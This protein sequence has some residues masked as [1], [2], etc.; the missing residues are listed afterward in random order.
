VTTTVGPEVREAI[1]ERLAELEGQ[2]EAAK[3]HPG[4]WLRHT[5]AVDP[6]SGEEFFFRFEDGWEWQWD[7]LSAYTRQQLILR[8]KARQLG[9]SWLGIGYCAWKCITRPGMR[10]L[11]VSINET[12]AI[13]LVNRAWDLWENTP[14]HLRFD[15]KVIK[16]ERGRPSSRIEWEFPDGR[17]SSLLAMPSTPRAGHG[18]TAGVIFLD[19]FG[20]HQFAHETYKAFI[21]VMA[22]SPDTQL[23]IVST[24][25]GYGNLFYELWTEAA[26]RD[27]SAVFIGADAHP[28]RDE[29]WFKRMRR[30]L[31]RADMAEQYPL[32]AAEAFTGTAGCWFDTEALG[33]YAEKVRKPMRRGVFATADDG[34][35]ATFSDRPDG[36]LHI[37]DQPEKDR[38]YALYADVATGRGKDFTAAVVIDLTN[39]NIAAELHGKIDPDLAAEQLH[40]LGRRFNTARLA[41]EMGGGYGEA[42]VIS[43]RDGRKGRRPYPKLYRHVQDDRP[44]Y[45][46]NAT[47]GF[48][49]T[50][51]TRP[52]IINQLEQA[53]REES[54]PHLPMATILECKTFV[55]QDTLPSPRAADGANDDRVMALAGG[56]EM[57][58]RYGEHPRDVRLSR[59]RERREYQPDYAW[60]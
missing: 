2:V 5:K 32:N 60:S 1:R 30:R 57:Y 58:R 53:I 6:K 13:K 48:P 28:G 15:A 31:S 18:E 55:R 40:F 38:G 46:Q 21:P 16:P 7:E 23:I 27:I 35:S 50:N 52:L 47:Y 22:D 12:E 8:L 54:L 34:A 42:I 59:R 11:C 45:K 29:S 17:V 44:D 41:I 20:R 10:S 36:W 33:R 25:N 37:Y 9:V 51:K 56:L 26:N 4:N 14:E 39:M 19:E 24:A 49:I 3:Q 43:L